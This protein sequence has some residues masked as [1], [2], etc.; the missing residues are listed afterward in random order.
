MLTPGII[1][2]ARRHGGHHHATRSDPDPKK[3]YHHHPVRPTTFAM[4]TLAV[5]Q[6][7]QEISHPEE[8]GSGQGEQTTAVTVA[9]IADDRDGQVLGNFGSDGNGVDLKLAVVETG[10]K[11]R[12]VERERGDGT[13]TEASLKLVSG[14][15]ST[16]RQVRHTDQ[17]RT[18]ETRLAYR[19]IL[20]RNRWRSR[21]ITPST[22][23][24]S[25]LTSSR[26][27][28]WS[29][30]RSESRSDDRGIRC[31]SKLNLSMPSSALLPA[32]LVSMLLMEEGTEHDDG[33]TCDCRGK[34]RRLCRA[35]TTNET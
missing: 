18:A 15:P 5:G 12:S 27:R 7:R 11:E 24:L 1:L 32:P 30:P 22:T 10:E 33:R 16:Q 31:S 21:S 26:R 9:Q 20:R 28:P 35:T 25:R 34:C 14:M 6:S 23:I 29:P 2:G 19:M 13:G 17:Q 4:R 3:S 8:N